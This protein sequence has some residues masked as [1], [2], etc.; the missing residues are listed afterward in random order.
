MPGYFFARAFFSGFA[1][2]FFLKH[3]AQRR[4]FRSTK[5]GENLSGSAVLQYRQPI[6]RL[7]AGTPAGALTFGFLPTFP[8]SCYRRPQIFARL[9]G[10]RLKPPVPHGPRQRSCHETP[11]QSGP[12]G[13]PTGPPRRPPFFLRVEFALR[14]WRESKPNYE[15]GETT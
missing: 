5:L 2:Y 3:A 13:T 9:A 11:V 14:F 4:P 12:S 15:K 6:P 1:E 10:R 8:L 7:F